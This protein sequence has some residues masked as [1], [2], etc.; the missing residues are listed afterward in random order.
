MP[1][2]AALDPRPQFAHIQ[3]RN[4]PDSYAWALVERVSGGWQSG[5][6]HYPD[7]DVQDIR[8]LYLVATDPAAP[9]RDGVPTPTELREAIRLLQIPLNED[10]L[11]LAVM[12]PERQVTCLLAVLASWITA[13]QFVHDI[14][15]DPLTPQQLH[16][17]V[18]SATAEVAD[19]PAAAINAAI[20]H[21]QWAGYINAE[22][23]RTGRDNASSPVTAVEN[24][25]RA[26][27]RV[28]TAWRDATGEPGGLSLNGVHYSHTS[29]TQ[30]QHARTETK[31]A[32]SAINKLLAP[33]KG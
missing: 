22:I 20:W 18:S 9:I 21:I 31:I 27:A 11:G 8:P 15:T 1:A 23:G 17:L 29:A 3:V 32:L 30:V 14:E 7:E 26:A 28:L 33:R 2:D 6:H 12:T 25:L 13:Y 4:G 5:A 10:R 16:A 19:E 24:L